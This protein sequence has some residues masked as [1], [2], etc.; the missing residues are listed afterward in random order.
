MTELFVIFVIKKELAETSSHKD[1]VC[2]IIL[3]Y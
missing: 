3:L 2:P 1:K